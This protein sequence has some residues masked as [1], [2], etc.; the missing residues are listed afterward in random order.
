MAHLA[1]N[2]ETRN[3]FRVSGGD[4]FWRSAIGEPDRTGQSLLSFCFCFACSRL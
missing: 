2:R 3:E 4:L 1:N